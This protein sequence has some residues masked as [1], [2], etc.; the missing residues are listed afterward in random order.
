MF[1]FYIAE[2]RLFLLLG[3]NFALS[4]CYLGEHFYLFDLYK[5]IVVPTLSKSENLL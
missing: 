2:A 3:R 4:Y 5:A 1:L